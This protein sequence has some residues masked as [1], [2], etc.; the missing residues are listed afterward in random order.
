MKNVCAFMLRCRVCVSKHA[1]V[2]GCGWCSYH[3]PSQYPHVHILITL[4][5][6]DEGSRA[7]QSLVDLFRI[8]LRAHSGI[9]LSSAKDHLQGKIIGT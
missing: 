2:C 7:A 6:S 8:L 3:Y 5:M 9:S 1:R 4:S